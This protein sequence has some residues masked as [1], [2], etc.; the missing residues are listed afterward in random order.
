MYF[1]A[2][3]GR[4]FFGGSVTLYISLSSAAV[5]YHLAVLCA[6][7]TYDRSFTDRAL[8]RPRTVRVITD[9]IFCVPA[10]LE[11]TNSP[12]LCQPFSVHLCQPF[13]VRQLTTEVFGTFITGVQPKQVYVAAT[14]DQGRNIIN[15]CEALGITTLQCLCHRVNSAVM[16]AT[17]INGTPATCKNKN[18]RELV[19][20]A[21]ALVGMFSHSCTNSDAFRAL[22]DKIIAKQREEAKERE[23]AKQQEMEDFRIML[24]T[25]IEESTDAAPAELPPDGLPR[26]LAFLRRNDTKWG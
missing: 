1:G 19:S 17:G 10:P 15:A 3:C 5:T 13:S 8:Q 26:A 4:G 6:C 21:A 22:Q 11:P 20:K 16:W 9:T 2:T 23:E 24:A 18:G 12:V 25:D 14:V 7:R